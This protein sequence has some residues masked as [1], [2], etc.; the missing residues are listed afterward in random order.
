MAMEG[1]ESSQGT[2]SAPPPTKFAFTSMKG[3]VRSLIL[4]TRGQ[5]EMPDFAQ[6]AP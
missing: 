6:D 3:E 4:A 2:L 1:H 5:V